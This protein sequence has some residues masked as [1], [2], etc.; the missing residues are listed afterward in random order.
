MPTLGGQLPA[1]TKTARLLPLSRSTPSGLLSSHCLPKLTAALQSFGQGSFPAL[2][3]E[4]GTYQRLNLGPFANGLPH[5]EQVVCHRAAAFSLVCC[6]ETAVSSEHPHEEPFPLAYC[7][8]DVLYPD[9][10]STAVFYCPFLSS[11]ERTSHAQGLTDLSPRLQ[12][13]L[14]KGN[15]WIQC[16]D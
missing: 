13:L 9:C 4:A 10:V 14:V 16:C 5:A 1:C 12:S 7:Q 8:P 3:A 2:F 15:K 6:P 11:K